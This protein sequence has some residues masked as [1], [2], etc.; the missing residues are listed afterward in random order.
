MS[1]LLDDDSLLDLR[2][3]AKPTAPAAVLSE[4]RQRRDAVGRRFDQAIVAAA[5]PARAEGPATCAVC[6]TRPARDACTACGRPACAADLWI[7]LRLC[8]SCADDR[9]VARGQRG[10]RPEDRNWLQGGGP[11]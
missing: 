4:E 7:M 1:D 5:V 10:A 11:R 9:D 6:G 8:R 2:R 3:R